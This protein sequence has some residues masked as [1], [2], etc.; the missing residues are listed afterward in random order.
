MKSIPSTMTAPAKYERTQKIAEAMKDALPEVMAKAEAQPTS[1]PI[2][3]K[4]GQ[5]RDQDPFHKGTET[6]TIYSLADCT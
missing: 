3:L 1:E 6:A 2:R 5:F 4:S